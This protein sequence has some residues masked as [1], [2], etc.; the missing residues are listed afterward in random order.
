[1]STSTFIGLAIGG[2]AL[3]CFGAF[4]YTIENALRLCSLRLGRIPPWLVVC[5]IVVPIFGFFWLF[6]VVLALNRSLAA[7]YRSRNLLREWRSPRGTC[8]AE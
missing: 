7:E 8:Q 1:M 5:L 2:A 3:L 6:F 4:L